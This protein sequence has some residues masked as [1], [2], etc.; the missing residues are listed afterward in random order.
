MDN[1]PKKYIACCIGVLMAVYAVVVNIPSV[2]AQLNNESGINNMAINNN[3]ELIQNKHWIN[4]KAYWKKLNTLQE[5]KAININYEQLQKLQE[6]I[7]T[8]NK[9]IDSLCALKLITVEQNKYLRD[10]IEERLSYLNYSMGVILCYRMSQMGSQ[11]AQK[12]GDL[13]KRYD[14]LEKLFS[15]DKID[16]KTFELTKNKLIEDIK[17]IDENGSNN[18]EFKSVEG[19]TDL[20]ILL[21]K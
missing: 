5:N 8:V 13:E 20:I 16:Q 6:E 21:N 2:R 14:T 3:K 18:T 15:E 12:R 1:N 9:D 17:F 10:F 19:I 11:V 7:K 4:I